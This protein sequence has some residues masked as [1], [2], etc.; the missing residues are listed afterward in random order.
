MASRL[1]P[2]ADEI[3][4]RY[5]AGETALALAQAY[6]VAHS[7]MRYFLAIVCQVPM[8]PQRRG[9][10][11][12]QE[13]AT[14]RAIVQA[15]RDGSSLM[16]IRRQYGLRYETVISIL[17]RHGITRCRGTHMS[18]LTVPTDRARLGYIA[19]LVDGEG[20]ISVLQRGSRRP[21]ASV[22]ISNTDTQLMEWLAQLGGHVYWERKA[23]ARGYK[24]RA[25]WT[26]AQALGCSRLLVA[27]EPYLVIKRSK[28]QEAL[29]TLQAR[30]GFPAA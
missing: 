10:A 8:R 3:T 4:R 7:T 12:S 17:R 21:R 28:A 19:G 30:W 22:S 24:R 18:T 14:E 2:F 11:P 23:H 29:A 6:G 27:I 16:D 26:V 5:R 13:P 25:V 15:Y 9:S 1:T 20:T